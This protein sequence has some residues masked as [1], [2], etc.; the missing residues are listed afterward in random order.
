MGKQDILKILHLYKKEVANEYKISEIGIFGS[1]A[2]GEANDESD[3]D[4]VIRISE[5]DFFKLAGIKSDLEDRLKKSVDI[6]T[7]TDTMNSFLKKRIDHEA[8]YA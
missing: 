7:Y 3:V 8:V 2:R 5:P 1:T 6:I 4:V